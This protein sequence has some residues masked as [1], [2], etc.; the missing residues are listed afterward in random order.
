MMSLSVCFILFLLGTATSRTLWDPAVHSGIFSKAKMLVDMAN[1][2][3]EFT[4]QRGKTLVAEMSVFNNYIATE[5]QPKFAEG[6]SGQWPFQMQFNFAL[7]SLFAELSPRFQVCEVGFN[8]GH[9]AHTWLLSSNHTNV[10][11][12]SLD[13][14]HARVI[15]DYL[16]RRYNDRLSMVWGNTMSTLPQF[17]IRNPEV[18]CDLMF[19]DGGHQYQFAFS[20]LN[21]M[22]LLA[23]R[24]LNIV[25]FDDSPCEAPFCV[26]PNNA[27]DTCVRGHLLKQL[28]QCPMG[29]TGKCA[30]SSESGP[31]Q[32]AFRFG[33]YR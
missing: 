8:L 29:T 14:P 9:S 28:S 5:V 31:F 18:K 4:S 16:N 19:V 24:G 22:R 23:R 17:D 3:N 13:T 26:G 1:E 12:F 27:W 2:D 6:H 30:D 25:V 7:S 11:S 20:D 32:R 33:V 21:H 10:L 15:A